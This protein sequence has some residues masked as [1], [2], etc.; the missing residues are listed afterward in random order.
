MEKGFRDNM[1]IQNGFETSH[2]HQKN[3]QSKI[4]NLHAVHFVD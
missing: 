1:S 2:E 4:A 3:R